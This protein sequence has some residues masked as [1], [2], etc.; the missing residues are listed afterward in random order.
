[1]ENVVY[2]T[3]LVRGCAVDVGV[4]ETV[5]TK[6]GKKTK[7]RLEIDFV[8]NRGAKKYYLQGYEDS[9]RVIRRGFTSYTKEELEQFLPVLRNEIALVE[10]R[11]VEG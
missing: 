7:K 8:V 4:V 1:M 10:I 3:L 9:E 11:G 5:E 6:D 2:N